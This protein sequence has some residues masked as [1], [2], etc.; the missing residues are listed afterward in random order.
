MKKKRSIFTIILTLV[1][2]L[3]IPFRPADAADY[4]NC[5]SLPSINYKTTGFTGTY[6]TSLLESISHWNTIPKFHVGTN[7]SAS[8]TMTLA[9]Y[10]E[11]WYGSNGYSC[12]GSSMTKSTI[13]IN[14]ATLA[15]IST[16]VTLKNIARSTITHEIGH[17]FGLADNPVSSTPNKSLMNHSRDRATIYNLTTYD[18]TNLANSY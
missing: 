18:Q 1:L 13:K 5:K 9:A 6:S 17:T 12:S 10:S 16:T 8:N 7:S 15:N 3:L 2:F 4:L 14:S 11:T